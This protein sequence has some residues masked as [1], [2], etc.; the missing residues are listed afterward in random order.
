M[1]FPGLGGPSCSLGPGCRPPSAIT[2]WAWALISWGAGDNFSWAVKFKNKFGDFI[3]W[4]L[5]LCFLIQQAIV[6]FW[7]GISSGVLFV[8]T[9]ICVFPLAALSWRYLEYPALA[10]KPRPVKDV[11]K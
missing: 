4:F 3:L 5:Y 1:S 10:R 7:P 9:L 6:N 8:A 2:I 11:D